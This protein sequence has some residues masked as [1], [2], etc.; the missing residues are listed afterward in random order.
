MSDDLRPGLQETLRVIR[1]ARAKLTRAEIEQYADELETEGAMESKGILPEASFARE[2][3]NHTNHTHIPWVNVW[4]IVMVALYVLWLVTGEWQLLVLVPY[5]AL[6][7]LGLMIHAEALI[8]RHWT[9][10]VD[11]S[12]Q[13]GITPDSLSRFLVLL[14]SLFG[15]IFAFVVIVLAYI[16]AQTALQGGALYALVCGNCLAVGCLMTFFVTGQHKPTFK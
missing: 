3:I 15:L 5:A 7:M 10:Y 6:P 4:A 2:E 12:K 14:G 9:L 8:R 1:D 13:T 16:D 11:L